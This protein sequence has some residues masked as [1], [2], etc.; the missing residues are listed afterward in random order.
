MIRKRTR[1]FLGFSSVVEEEE[2]RAVKEGMRFK[3]ILLVLI[4]DYISIIIV[5]PYMEHH[6]LSADI[7]IVKPKDIIIFIDLNRL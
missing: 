3:I 1:H 4:I 2:I 6:I 7:R 5:I